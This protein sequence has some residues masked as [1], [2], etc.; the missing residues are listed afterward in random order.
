ML[1]LCSQDLVCF[2]PSSAALV[3]STQLCERVPMTERDMLVDKIF[4]P[5]E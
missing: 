5:Y 3:F 4:L 1:V 2:S